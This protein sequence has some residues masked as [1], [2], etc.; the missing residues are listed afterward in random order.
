MNSIYEK[1]LANKQVLAAVDLLRAYEYSENQSDQEFTLRV[2]FGF[3]GSHYD[4]SCQAFVP[5]Y[6]IGRN[7]PCY[8]RQ[9]MA[10]Y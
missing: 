2:F 6:P 1:Y 7:Y 10:N 8:D 9:D 3:R 4:R 5:K